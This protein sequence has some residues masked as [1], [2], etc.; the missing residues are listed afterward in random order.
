LG[1]FDI[2]GISSGAPYGYS[3]GYRFP[4]KIGHIFILSGI[5]ALYDDVVLSD[6]PYEPISDQSIAS[7]E[8]LAYQLF[9]SRLTEED[10]LRNDIKDS[11][12]NHGFGV[13]QDLRL[14][15]VDWGFRLSEVKSKVFMR[16]SKADESVPFRTAV[17][18][19]ALLPNC[20]LDLLE[21]GPH[22]SQ[23]VLD[24]FIE[25]TILPNLAD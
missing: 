6:W 9:F 22:F 8:D 24:Q 3:I 7:L 18:T 14:R 10:L 25:E 1:Q 13:A 4:E 15:F 11:L 16:H 19:S 2:L 21:S 17:R 5:P 23:E 20:Q 12:M